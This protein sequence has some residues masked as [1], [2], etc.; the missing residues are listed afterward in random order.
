MAGI[1]TLQYAVEVKQS[2]SWVTISAN[3]IIDVS[4][5][6]SLSPTDAPLGFGSAADNGCRITVLR[7]ALP[8]SWYLL[9]IRVRYAFNGG[10]YVD[11]F[12]GLITGYSGD[13]ATVELACT[14]FAELVRTTRA[15]SPMFY[16]RP[17]FTVTTA[18]SIDD[19]T[20]GGYRGGLGNYLLWQAGGRPYQQAASYA[21]APFYYSCDQAIIAPKFSWTAGD[22]AWDECQKL[23]QAS[24]GQLFQDELGVIRYRQP[25][26]F[27][28][29]TAPS[30]LD[31]SVYADVRETAP[32]RAAWVTG[33][34]HVP[35]VER[36]LAPQQEV[37]SDTT[38]RLVVAGA[39]LTFELEPKLPLY[40]LVTSGATCDG[41]FSITFLHGGVPTLGTHYTRSISWTAQKVIITIANTTT[42]PIAIHKI[43]MYG[44]PIAA[45]EAGEYTLGSGKPERTQSE[46]EYIQNRTHAE[47][48]A[49]LQSVFGTPRSIYELTGCP[50]DTTVD[51][52]DIVSFTSSDLGLSAARSLVIGKSHQ[53]TAGEVSYAVCLV[54]D[55]P[56]RNDVFIIGSTY[57]P[58]DVRKLSI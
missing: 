54:S 55:L 37:I 20:N 10:A 8:V 14:G 32:R 12:N 50:Y 23:A 24:G 3:S 31:E 57:A 18:T 34:L 51:I 43:L 58:S 16:R 44:K 5:D 42:Q 1:R 33:A 39:S 13:L 29:G 41:G 46:S 36:Y 28:L 6:F 30:L 11:C 48:I 49:K 9:P 47:R 2:G 25:L 27:G 15:Y 19:P 45:G 40:S 52:G 17:I 21:T 35:Y 26:T 4:G 53:E 38:P 56:T 22:N 7:S